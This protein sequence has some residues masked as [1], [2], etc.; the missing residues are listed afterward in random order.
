MKTALAQENAIF[1]VRLYQNK[2]WENFTQERV[3][4]G[5]LLI[6]VDLVK[7][8]VEEN[9]KL[10]KVEKVVEEKIESQEQGED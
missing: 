8:E 7:D 5:S 9:K 6:K 2:F 1:E 4:T 10:E 3:D